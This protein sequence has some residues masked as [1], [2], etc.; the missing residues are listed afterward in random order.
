MCIYIH[1]E[2]E[3][4]R[5]RE[6][7]RVRA[8]M[9]EQ[10]SAG[11]QETKKTTWEEQMERRGSFASVE[12]EGTLPYQMSSSPSCFQVLEKRNQRLC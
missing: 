11:L 7:G 3:R 8:R 12:G 10:A 5:Y 1:S 4:E 6:R 9:T 2:R